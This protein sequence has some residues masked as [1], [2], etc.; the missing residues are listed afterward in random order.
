MAGSQ[1]NQLQI[2]TGPFIAAAVL[3]GVGGLLLFIGFIIACLHVLSEGT[4]LVGQMETPPNELAKKHLN[5][6]SLAAKAGGSAWRD[7]SPSGADARHN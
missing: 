7:Y 5:R 2:G 1:E 3:M 6:L 4:R